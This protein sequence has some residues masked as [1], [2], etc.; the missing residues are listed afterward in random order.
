MLTNKF[1]DNALV[2]RANANQLLRRPEPEPE[3]AGAIVSAL[4]FVLFAVVMAA[5]ITVATV[6]R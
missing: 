3:D 4:A 2:P 1:M 6:G 5:C